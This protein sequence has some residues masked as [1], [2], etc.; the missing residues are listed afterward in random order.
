MNTKISNHGFCIFKDNLPDKQLQK[1]KKE[2][3]V[4]P[5]SN[6]GNFSVN[7][8]KV[9][10]ETKN[11]L[12]IPV[13]YALDELKIKDYEISFPSVNFTK[14][15]D[16]IVLRDNQKN[17]FNICMQEFDKPF[18]GGIITLSTGQGKTIVSLKLIS[19]SKRK[20]LV[21]VNKKEL[22]D[23]WKRE[24][25]KWLPGARI[26][27]IQGAKFEYK[28]CDIVLGMLQT[29]S[30]KEQLTAID[31]NWVS[32]CIFDECHNISTEIF[33]KV[34]FKIRPRFIFGLTATLERKDRLEKIIKWYMGDILYDGTSK[35]LKQSTEVHVIKYYGASSVQKQL[36][37]GTAAVATMLTNIAN[38]K[39][40]NDKIIELLR[41]HLE[42]NVD[43]NIL[44]ISDRIAQLKY[45]NKAI[46]NINSG[47]F[48]GS[49]KSVELEK[50]KEKR[51]ILGTYPLVNEGFNLP[52]LN[53]LLFATPRSSITQA[54]GRIYRKTHTVTP[55]II[56][57]FDDFSIFKGQHYKRRKIYKSCIKDCV[58]L[59]KNLNEN[60]NCILD[61]VCLIE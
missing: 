15:T 14:L 41:H 21:I 32:T 35:E 31:F 6:F 37:D 7:S 26:G 57:V 54:I 56:D 53:C 45:I 51:I 24:I 8:F 42:A 55:I 44:V 20:T 23:Q 19:Q 38:D 59:Y 58:I 34:M 43:R 12:I 2:L 61:D 52:K 18:G 16:N 36:R 30:I 39:E 33:S 4:T 13:Y 48:I 3:N 50:T 10:K 47:L 11:Y 9:Y 29:I 49:M 40:R 1:I 5:Y 46:G 28:N 22:L 60:E 27:I 25:T 17:T